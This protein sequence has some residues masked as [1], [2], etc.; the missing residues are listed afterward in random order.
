MSQSGETFDTL[1]AVQEVK[2]KGGRV[3]GIVNVVGSTIA[4]ECGRGDLSA[5]GPGSRVVA[6]KTFTCT[7]VAFALLGFIS[8]GCATLSTGHGARLLAA[9]KAL[10]DRSST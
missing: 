4:R 9:L 2:R 5:R 8:A 3:L 1:A 7:A 10:P 6:T